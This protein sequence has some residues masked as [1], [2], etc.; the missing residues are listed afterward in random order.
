MSDLYTLLACPKDGG[1]LRSTERALACATCDATYPVTDGVVS[2]IDQA[3][4]S[5]VDRREQSGRD[6]RSDIGVAARAVIKNR[7]IAQRWRG[8]N[9]Y[10]GCRRCR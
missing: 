5:D 3:E 9:R 7:N 1:D 10:F 8:W 2:F 4:L 6:E